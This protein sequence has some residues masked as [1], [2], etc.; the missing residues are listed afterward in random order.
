MYLVRNAPL[1]TPLRNEPVVLDGVKPAPS[2]WL[3]P[4]LD[5][6]AHPERWNVELAQSGPSSWPRTSVTHIRPPVRPVPTTRVSAVEQTDSSVSFHVSRIGTP[7][8]VKVSYFPNWH[9]GGADGPWRVTP[10]L[11]VVVPTSHQ[12]TLSYGRSAADNLGQALSLMGLVVLA[13]LFIVPAV[14]R[15]WSGSRDETDGT[16]TV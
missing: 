5:W 7:V 6:Y 15:W 12:V 8:L 16:E 9:A 14:R 10:N 3:A 13:L 4:S 2:S 11:M 1:V